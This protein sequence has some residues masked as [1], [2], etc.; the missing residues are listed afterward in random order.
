MQLTKSVYLVSGANYDLLGNVYAIRGERGVALVDS[1]E[2]CAA[3]TIE[4]SLARWGMGGLPVTHLF[5]THGHADHAGCAAYFQKKGAKIVVGE[6][7]AHWLRQGGFPADLTPYGDA[8]TYSPLEPDAVF[9]GKTVLAFEDFRL[10]A[11]PL[12]GHTDG[13][14]FFEMEDVGER[15]DGAPGR[16]VLFTGDTFSFDRECPESVVLCWKGSPDYDPAKLRESFEFAARH[17]YPDVILSG[18][19]M[20]LFAN[21]NAVIRAAARKFLVAYR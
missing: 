13:S 3:E 2:P 6:G 12:P 16:T 1:G 4:S 5:L 17:F 18:H 21:G 10:T 14:A 7:D 20:P 9:A 11:Y 8:W 15:T 19:G